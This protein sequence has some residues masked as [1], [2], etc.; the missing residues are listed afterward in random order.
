MHYSQDLTH[1]YNLD[2]TR[3]QITNL[4]YSRSTIR[5]KDNIADIFEASEEDVALFEKERVQD[6]TA[7]M[8][9]STPL[10]DRAY[11]KLYFRQSAEARLYKREQYDMLTYFGDLGGLLDFVIWF[12]WGL[13]TLI[14]T[15]LFDAA[16]IKKAYRVQNYLLDKTPY[17][18]SSKPELLTTESEDRDSGEN[19][20]K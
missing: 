19:G 5:L 16:L 14:V 17:Y 4:F 11:V 10:K 18:K 6:I 3:S 15:R 13:S 7:W 12:G 20:G 9:P 2:P 1:F 8:A